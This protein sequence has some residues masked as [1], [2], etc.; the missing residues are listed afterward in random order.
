MSQENRPQ[1]KPTPEL[2]RVLDNLAPAL[3]QNFGLKNQNWKL[4]S[5][6]TYPDN[7]NRFTFYIEGADKRYKLELEQEVRDNNQ[8]VMK[9]LQAFEIVTK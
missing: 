2:Q 7:P 8:A 9:I 4:L 3:N 5:F 1:Y 6:S